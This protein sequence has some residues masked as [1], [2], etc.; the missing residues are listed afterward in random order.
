[1]NE[2]VF[3]QWLLSDLHELGAQCLPGELVQSSKYHLNG[4]F[5]LQVMKTSIQANVWDEYLLFLTI[6]VFSKHF[7]FLNIG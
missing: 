3:E 7:S 6:C 5:A 4:I 1:V 2:L